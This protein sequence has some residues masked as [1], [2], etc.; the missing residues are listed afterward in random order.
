MGIS[1][2]LGLGLDTKGIKLKPKFLAH[3]RLIREQTDTG[4]RNRRKFLCPW[5]GMKLLKLR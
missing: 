2:T 3:L 4:K 1:S 5:Q